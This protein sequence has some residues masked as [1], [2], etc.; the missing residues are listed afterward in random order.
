M[1]IV[2]DEKLLRIP[3]VDSSMEE[4]FK[5]IDLLNKTLDE[6][7]GI[8]LSAN[9][10]GILKKVFV[11]RVPAINNNQK[12]I[13]SRNFINPKIVSRV[14]PILFHNEGCLSFPN[15]AIET[16]RYN[17]IVIIDDLQPDGRILSGLEAVAAQ[18]EYD[19]TLGKTMYDSKIQNISPND[20]CLCGSEKK[21]KKC[22]SLIVKR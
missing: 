7:P 9:Q 21:Y 2:T 11:L 18:H 15:K 22:C 13:Y 19:H 8:G 10:I 1:K 14:D 20:K 5:I 4:G 3:S 16:L 6:N 12:V 17:Q